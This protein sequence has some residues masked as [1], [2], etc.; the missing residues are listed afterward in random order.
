MS[1]QAQGPFLAA[2]HA[3]VRLVWIS[4]VVVA[5]PSQQSGRIGKLA[6]G[7]GQRYVAQGR[8]LH[9]KPDSHPVRALALTVAGKLGRPALVL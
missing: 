1:S 3:S 5:F 6:A 4:S 9:S 7:E 2:N 8:L